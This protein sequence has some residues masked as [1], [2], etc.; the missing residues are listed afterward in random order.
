MILSQSIESSRRIITTTDGLASATV[1]LFPV[2]E[3][4]AVTPSTFFDSDV[5]ENSNATVWNEYEIE[6]ELGSSSTVEVVSG[7]VAILGG[8]RVIPVGNGGLGKVQVVDGAVK[9][10]IRV[11]T[12]KIGG[13]THLTFV[14]YTEGSVAAYLRDQVE[15]MFVENPDVNYYSTYNHATATYTRN[16]S[17]WAADIDLSAVAVASNTGAG[18]TRQRG[19]TLITARHVLL[20][21]HFPLSV[22]AQLRFAGPD[23]TVETRTI[24]GIENSGTF[25]DML[26]A[27]LNAAVTVATPCPIPDNSWFAKGVEIV[28]ESKTSYIGGAAIHT[29]QNGRVYACGLDTIRKQSHYA[30]TVSFN[31]Q[32]YQTCEFRASVFHSQDVFT[33]GI[34]AP[35]KFPVSGDSGQPVMVVIDGSPVLMFCWTFST[36]GPPTWREGGA[37]LNALIAAADAAAGVSTGLTVT[38]APDPTA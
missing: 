20:A 33:G 2:S 21:R 31:G 1:E 15:S 7:P 16:P 4:A 30:P 35:L 18:W 34:S 11:N 17:C 22:G 19:G 37:I 9:N 25:G 13:E 32:S 27:T 8:N 36:A 28:V 26:V 3:D 10:I 5:N 24:I 12:E 6:P 29:D 23:G 38:V 14:D